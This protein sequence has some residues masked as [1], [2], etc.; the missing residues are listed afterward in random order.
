MLL[1]ALVRFANHNLKQQGLIMKK[2]V[3][4][5]IAVLLGGGQLN[6]LESAE[7]AAFDPDAV[8]AEL[9]AAR[10]KLADAETSAVKDS[11]KL[12]SQL[13]EVNAELENIR[14]DRDKMVR[15]RKLSEIAS[16]AGCESVEYLDFLAA[17]AGVDLDDSNA[18]KNFIADAEKKNPHCFK[19]KCRS[20]SGAGTPP[21]GEDA[22]DMLPG[23]RFSYPGTHRIDDIMS[24]LNCAPEL[25]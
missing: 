21:T 23:K 7:L 1:C 3:R 18:V 16:A 5:M 15:S 20:G 13:A 17:S 6:A 12:R 19:S 4:E 11:D 10:R 2:T 25:N 9:A 8:A 14:R 24:D 22:Q